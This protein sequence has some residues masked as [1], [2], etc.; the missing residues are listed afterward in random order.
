MQ[1]YTLYTD[2]NENFECEVAVKNA[3]LKGSSARLIV[4]SGEGVNYVFEGNINGPKCT[5]P[6][7]RLKGLLEETTRG[8]MYLEIIVE[9]TVFRPWKSDY[10]VE[11]HTEVN[12]RLNENVSSNKPIVDVKVPL[13]ENKKGIN[14]W[15]PLK[16][17]STICE[18][19]NITRKTLNSRKKDLIQILREY[20]EANPEFVLY[21]QPILHGLK[22][23]LK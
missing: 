10:L 11:S 16:E 23:V 22:T 2:R 14:M 12:V 17:I 7:R 20:F 1:P 15:I 19:F 6:V 9:D 4:E 13:K 8:K 21:K 18:A 5:I 3:S